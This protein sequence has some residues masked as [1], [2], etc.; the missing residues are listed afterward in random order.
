MANPPSR[1]P[2]AAWIYLGLIGLSI[3]VL[4]FTTFLSHRAGSE[5]RT[6][7]SLLLHTQDVSGAASAT[8]ALVADYDAY[9]RGYFIGPNNLW[10]L[11]RANVAR[12]KL[13]Q[14]VVALERLVVDDTAQ[15]ELAVELRDV[16]DRRL[17]YGE[18]SMRMHDR[19]T[20][21]PDELARRQAYATGLSEEARRL[22]RDITSNERAHFQHR[23]NQVESTLRD[24]S[25]VTLIANGLALVAG[26]LGI[27]LM[28]RAST[29]WKHRNL[30]EVEA[31]RAMQA[32]R[33]KSAFLASMS[34]EIRT[35]MNA[36]FGFSQLLA[37]EV[38]GERA[39]QYVQAITTSGRSLLALINDILDLS[40][41]EAG[42]L[43]VNVEQVDIRDLLET[44]VSVFTQM[45]SDKGLGL[46]IDVAPAVPAML[47]LDPARMRQVLFNLIG[48]AIKYTD[49]GSVGV[50]AWAD[51]LEGQHALR[52]HIAVDDT[53]I[54]IAADQLARIFEP[55]VRA[56]GETSPREGT[57]LGLS[58]VRRV[59]ELMGGRV[60]VTS[61]PDR[62]ST[63]EVVLARVETASNRRMPVSTQT[64]P[65]DFNSLPAL[66]VLVV[67]DVALNRQ[68]LAAY[69][70]GTHHEV[71]LAASGQEGIDIAAREVPDLVL[72][73]IRMPG[74]D[75]REA[76]QQMR[77]IATLERT[78]VLAVTAS[79]LAGD[80]YP[81]RRTFD[82][83]LRKPFSQHELYGELRRLFVNGV[84]AEAPAVATETPVPSNT[85]SNDPE[86]NAVALA[87][88]EKLA[89]DRWRALCDSLAMRDCRLFAEEI[90]GHAQTL[91]AAELV[92]YADR[93]ANAIDR[94]DITS[95]ESLLRQFP[96]YCRAAGLVAGESA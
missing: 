30:A 7:I 76:R 38:R 77:R 94:F 64:Q 48:N 47:M 37:A 68:L 93:L 34:H 41:I 69:F 70:D 75:G 6:A 21:Q 58:I 2:F 56:Q 3:V 29:A 5:L 12:D 85:A 9:R 96:A 72:M 66:K 52:L 24:T 60:T 49:R 82:G 36:I 73:D 62:G 17:A 59:V 84:Q 80:E 92:D 39:Q 81:L 32:S 54:G 91:G 95:T 23:W 42:R 57:G 89:G 71:L 45:A 15:H 27:G 16:I 46:R 1:Q 28:L 8:H 78:R 14:Q 65:V 67:D 44:T 33:E 51:A 79:S 87:A 88:L 61:E 40:K 4:I 53:G 22:T 83:Y 55:F 86:A 20:L 13:Q 43:E 19:G 31:E 90:R 74:M 11:D 25:A 63:F 26:L 10:F 18:E 50:R 35:P